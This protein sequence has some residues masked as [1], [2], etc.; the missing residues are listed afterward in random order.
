MVFFIKVYRSDKKG[1]IFISLTGFVL[2]VAILVVLNILRLYIAD[3]Y[4]QYMPDMT[5]VMS[6]PERVVRIAMVV[7]AV[8]YVV[9]IVV[10]LPTWYRTFSYTLSEDRVTSLTGL[11]SRTQ[12]IMR[13]DSIQHV[14][15]IKLP[16][17]KYTS[18]NFISLNAMGGNLMMNFLSCED[19]DEIMER[20][21][22]RIGEAPAPPAASAAPEWSSLSQELLRSREEPGEADGSDISGDDMQLSF[23]GN[24]PQM[25]FFDNGE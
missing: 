19:C 20:L 24:V 3:R 16:L 10:I 9:F 17:S 1:R 4:P 23:D 11:F 25:S 8:L 14:T 15:L 5:R 18:F 13:I 2:T 6:L 7:F 22:H 12:R 21:S